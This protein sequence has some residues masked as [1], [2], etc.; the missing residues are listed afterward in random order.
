MCRAKRMKKRDDEGTRTYGDFPLD[1]TRWAQVQ[2][3]SLRT[4]GIVNRRGGRFRKRR[5][6]LV[7]EGQSFE[8]EATSGMEDAS[9]PDVAEVHAKEVPERDVHSQYLGRD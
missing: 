9:D 3:A 6:G 7:E 2:P 4:L 5:K 1:R 8:A